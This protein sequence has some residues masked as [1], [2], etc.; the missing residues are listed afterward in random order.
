MRI[1]FSTW[2][3]AVA[4][5]ALALPCQAGV[6]KCTDAAGRV[7]YQDAHCDPAPAAK[8]AVSVDVRASDKPKGDVVPR[9]EALPAARRRRRAPRARAG[10]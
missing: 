9:R 5:V 1:V 2:W 10:T 7:V 4:A 8:P 6:R 3:L